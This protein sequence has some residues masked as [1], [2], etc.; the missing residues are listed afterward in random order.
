VV[1]EDLTRML[2]GFLLRPGIL[3]KTELAHSAPPISN[4]ILEIKRKKAAMLC[5]NVRLID[6]EIRLMSP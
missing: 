1:R 5:L 4:V 2:L 3:A 6:S